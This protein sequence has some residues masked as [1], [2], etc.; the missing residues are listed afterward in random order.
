MTA[1]QRCSETTFIPNPTWSAGKQE[2]L[3]PRIRE[4]ARTDT[5]KRRFC[6]SAPTVIRKWL[7]PWH[8]RFMEAIREPVATLLFRTPGRRPATPDVE[9]LMTHL[10]RE[11]EAALWHAKRSNPI[12]LA[13]EQHTFLIDRRIA[14][15][16]RPWLPGILCPDP[17]ELPGHIVT[18]RIP[19]AQLPA[20]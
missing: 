1:I 4:G 12:D 18:F 9:A 3:T 14:Q 13:E 10:A 7:G 20:D 11:P 5:P 2:F 16:I 6:G 15:P 19:L 17:V 8:W